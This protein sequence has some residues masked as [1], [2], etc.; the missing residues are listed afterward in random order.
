MEENCVK[1]NGFTLLEVVISLAVIAIISVGIYTGYIIMIRQT[2]DGQVKQEAAL[3]GK[4]VAEALKATDFT[5]GDSS[6]TVENMTFNK[7][8]TFYKRYL[9][10]DYK[11]TEDDGSK[12]TES[13]AK[14]IESVTFTPTV[15]ET[16]T[17]REAVSLDTTNDLDSGDNKIYIS[18][19]ATD[20]DDY[21]SY[22]QMDENKQ[23]ISLSNDSEVILSI[24]LTP[25]DGDSSH[26]NLKVVDYTNTSLVKTTKNI[27]DN[28]IINFSN[29]KK[30]NGIL[31]DDENIEINVYNQTTAP[32]NIYL[33]KQMD[34][35]VDLENRSGKVDLYNN[36]SENV[37]QDNIGTLYDIKIIIEDKNTMKDLFTG[38][39]KKNIH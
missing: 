34:L 39:Y 2:K 18:K 37:S 36:R 30:A 4:K 11:D 24:Y 3:E 17:T 19:S 28:L 35:N 20:S 25:I 5:P 27:S 7:V 13:T 23:K 31:P 15:A 29:Y 12:V 21:M 32:S 10:K 16:S 9:N 22:P 26:E 33:E 1:E 8:Q 14:Y 38:Y 6:I